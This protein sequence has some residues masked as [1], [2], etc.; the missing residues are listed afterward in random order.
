VR[1]FA[2]TETRDPLLTRLFAESAPPAVDLLPALQARIRREQRKRLWLSIGF[3]MAISTSVAGLAPLVAPKLAQ[4]LTA[5]SSSV[6]FTARSAEFDWNATPLLWP[7]L[8]LV[9]VAPAVIYAWRAWR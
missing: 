3:P 8:S 7:L 1:N 4:W 9:F 6:Q 2:S 5:L